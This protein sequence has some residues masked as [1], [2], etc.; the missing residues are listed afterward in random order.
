MELKDKIIEAKEK[1]GDRAAQIIAEELNI[2]KWDSKTLKGCCP[3]HEEDTPSFIWNPKA[4]NFHCFG[5]CGRN[6]DIIDVYMS[7][8]MSYMEAVKKLF[9]ESQIEFEQSFAKGINKDSYFNNYKFPDDETNTDISIAESYLSKRGISKET[10]D[11]VGIKQDF[12]GNIAFQ[13]K[14]VDGR[15]LCTKYRPARKLRDGE[16]KAFWQ[17]GKSTCPVLYGID[18]IDITKPLLI[19][20]GHIDML[21]CIE[22]GFTNTVSIPHGANDVNWIEFNWEWLENFDTIIIWSD[23]D[24]AG[25]KM[26]QEVV[27]RLGE[28]RCKIVK[29]TIEVEDAVARFY[30]QHN[31]DI[32]KTDANNVLIACGKQEVLN[33]IHNAEEIEDAEIKDLMTFKYCSIQDREKFSTGLVALDK[34]ISGHLLS[35]LTLY[36]GYTGAGKTTTINQIALKSFLEQGEKVFVFSGEMGGDKLMSWLLDSIAGANHMIE[37]DN[38]NSAPK[39]YSVTKEAVKAMQDYYFGNIQY[40]DKKGVITAQALFDKMEYC[41]RKYGIKHYFIDNLMC[42]MTKGSDDDKWESQIE[43]II[44]L[45]HFVESKNVGVHLVAHPRKPSA[46]AVQSIYDIAGVSELANACHRAFW[47]KKIDDSDEGYNSEILVL[48]DRETG[49]AGKSAKL[50]YDHKTRRLYSNDEELHEVCKWEQNT[51][52]IYPEKIKQKLVCNITHQERKESEPKW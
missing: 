47:I 8:N 17:K 33:T 15:L 49:M 50:F 31:R 36:T 30:S 44:K 29:P 52:I 43:F 35:C 27:P 24:T 51:N 46:Q 5:T 25:K 10:M 14:D 18:K 45:T 21:S 42:L 2:D 7:K 40:Y 28:F 37:W 16:D 11:Y 26:I 48:K 19:T 34:V 32:R 13:H 12:D 22:S 3:F 9:D 4:N 23:N 41:R 39:G 1:L 38:G 20:E 6:Y